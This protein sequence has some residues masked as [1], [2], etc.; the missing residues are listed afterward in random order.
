VLPLLNG[1][2]DEAEWQTATTVTTKNAV[3]KEN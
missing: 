3:P 2:V 1:P